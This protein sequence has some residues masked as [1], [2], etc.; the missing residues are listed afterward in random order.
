MDT[1]TALPTLGPT[2]RT[3]GMRSTQ[4]DT[5]HRLLT[6]RTYSTTESPTCCTY[7]FGRQFIGRR[8]EEARPRPVAHRQPGGA[9]PSAQRVKPMVAD[10]QLQRRA[11]LAL[12]GSTR[13][14]CGPDF[15]PQLRGAVPSFGVCAALGVGHH[16]HRTEGLSAWRKA[17]RHRH[18][19]R[20]R[21]GERL[22]EL[23]NELHGASHR[24]AAIGLEHSAARLLGGGEARHGRAGTRDRR[25]GNPNTHWANGMM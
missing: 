1:A 15:L 16:A 8:G 9:Q 7:P 11:T 20:S 2:S 6:R 3:T 12:S 5:N 10:R 21:Q 18:R 19:V 23:G 4:C 13:L 22:A 25:G 17:P 24:H 14:E